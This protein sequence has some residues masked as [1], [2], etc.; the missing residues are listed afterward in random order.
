MWDGEEIEQHVL[1]VLL[2]DVRIPPRVGVRQLLDPEDSPHPRPVG[3]LKNLKLRLQRAAI[4]IVIN[5]FDSLDQAVAAYNS[6]A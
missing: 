3:Q 2:H 5:Q 4:G 6:A 1:G